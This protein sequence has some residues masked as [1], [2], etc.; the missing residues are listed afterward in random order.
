[1]KKNFF[2]LIAFITL[3]NVWGVTNPNFI[4]S[5]HRGYS[6]KGPENTLSAFQLAIDAGADYFELDIRKTSD[7]SIVAIHD[8]TVNRTTDGTGNITTMTFAQTQ[9]LDAG[10]ASKFGNEY[11]GEKIPTLRESLLLAKGQIKVEIE[12]KESGLANS[13]VAI[14]QDLEMEDEVSVISFNY[15][16]IKRIKELDASIP[17]KYLIG[18]NWGQTEID[19]LLDIGGEFIGP[20]GVASPSLI[21]LAHNNNIKIIAYTFNSSTDIQNAIDAGLDGIATD[22][23]ER[24]IAL[25]N[26]VYIPENSLI[27]D[28]DFQ[29]EIIGGGVNDL[30]DFSNHSQAFGTPE[31]VELN[32]TKGLNF[33]GTEDFLQVPVSNSLEATYN[34]ITVM[35]KIK[36]DELPSNIPDSWSP[37]Y[38][39]DNDTY[40]MY[41]DKGG[42]DLRFKVTTEN[43]SQKPSIPESELNTTDWITVYGVY[44]GES[45]KIYL[46]DVLMDEAL[47]DGK[48]VNPQQAFIGKNGSNTQLFNGAISELKIYNYAFTEGMIKASFA[49]QSLIAHWDL[50]TIEN[51]SIVD[52][53]GY[54]SKLA[55]FGNPLTVKRGGYDALSFN[56]TND[57]LEVNA[58][59]ALDAAHAQLTITA[60]VKFNELPSEISDSW[61][62]VFDSDG[63]QFVLYSD[64]GS[65]EFRFKAATSG[66]AERPGISGNSLEKNVWYHIAGVYT[67]QKAQIFLNGILMDE[68]NLS[69]TVNT[70]QNA[71][72]GRN[73]TNTQYFNG[74]IGE[75]K[76]YNYAMSV[77]ELEKEARPSGLIALWK[78]NDIV[79]HDT[80]WDYSG[81]NHHLT[82]VG[83]PKPIVSNSAF[84]FDG[85]QNYL[86]VP[87]APL[88][89][90]VG[91][92]ITITSWVKL[93]ELPSQISDSWDPVFDSDEDVY[94]L[95]SDKGSNE[96]R[97]KISTTNG[98][99]R[100]GIPESLLS[101]DT[102]CLVAG[103]YDGQNAKVYINGQ[104]ADQH[105]ITGTIKTNQ[106]AFI[107]K[108]G[109]SD[110]YL[111]GQI[112]ETRIYNYALSVDSLLSLA[113]IDIV[114]NTF[115]AINKKR[116]N[117][118]PNPAEDHLIIN[119]DNQETISVR[120]LTLNNNKVR[121]FGTY[122]EQTIQLELS[123]INS[124]IYILEL[125]EGSKT[126]YQKV[127]VK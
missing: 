124:G 63:D 16:E 32:S 82:V 84:T 25:K 72:I 86:E 87:S 74:A 70:G 46:G 35:A 77:S 81:Y 14:V 89:D 44:N 30:S 90:S 104:L 71:F 88:L 98:A 83:N 112:G 120:L 101:T 23:P 102:W 73:G 11:N 45:V 52:F 15:N 53:S 47:L 119:R 18:N 68:H 117:V 19:L 125:K 9:L 121:D 58:S 40:V 59:P 80:V 114:T 39:S 93:N 97:F 26:G 85:T 110:Q 7:D 106:K 60:W 49:E 116:I 127:S 57:Y 94:V 100:P 41:L 13:V 24:A 75:I 22:Y 61:D 109:T 67:G 3:F 34:E 21:Q 37:I 36:L 33:D 56:G 10:Y 27:A 29:S 105:T 51:D 50:I 92:S 115:R 12:I 122:S 38:D 1:M 113:N 8:G 99:Q 5:A 79:D 118:Y 95:Y 65:N 123:N 62:P 69:G 42:N 107:A 111:N 64:K 2:T 43:G 20:S 54:D 31:S 91:S 103:V 76:V 55:V 28:W 96:F 6:S 108:N 4:V 66:G 78:M 126:T 17:V 48:I